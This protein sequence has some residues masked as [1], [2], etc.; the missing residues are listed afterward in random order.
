MKLAIFDVDGTL[1]DSQAMIHASYRAAFT[2]E[3]LPGAGAQA[4]PFHRRPVAPRRH[5]D[6]CTWGGGP[7]ATDCLAEAYKQAF[8]ELRAADAHPE[9]LF[10]GAMDLLRKLHARDDV[11][12]GIATGKSRRGV[13]HLMEKHGFGDWFVTVQTADDH[14]SKPH[15]AMIV[16]ALAET[17]VTRE[18][19]IMIGDTSFDIEM[20]RAARVWAAGVAWG[21]HHVDLLTHAGAHTISNDFNELEAH[22]EFL[23]Q[24]RLT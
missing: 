13:E 19:A 21:N 23:W 4:G 6:S 5:A 7:I 16:R 11:L 17:G 24:E 14:P 15:P 12:L 18:A 22:L 1:V 20:A 3:G 8:W 9:N 10:D 2:D